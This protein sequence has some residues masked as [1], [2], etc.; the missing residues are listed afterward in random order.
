MR[1][2]AQRIVRSTRPLWWAYRTT[3]RLRWRT[4]ARLV[5]EAGASIHRH[6]GYVLWDPEVESHSFTLANR[7]ELAVFASQLLGVPVGRVGVVLAELD[8]DPELTTRLTTRL[9]WRCWFK[10]RM[11]FG[12]RELWYV[13]ARLLRPSLIVETGIYDGLG[14]L[15]LLRAL[16]ANA[17]EGAPGE[18]I[19]V[20]DVAV[21]GELVARRLRGRWTKLTGLSSEVVEPAIAGRFVGLL[22]HDTPHTEQNQRAEFA[23]GLRHAADPLVI[24]EGSGGHC[25]TLDQLAAVL[26]LQRHH[27][28]DRAQGFGWSGGHGVLLV[29][30]DAHNGTTPVWPPL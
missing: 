28:A 15:V 5:K 23:L 7:D 24:V 2:R 16:E 3:G 12:N 27:F 14:S 25:P 29:P 6:L 10:N 8:D 21:S 26:G 20:D 11:S 19:S 9:R 22:L 1:S 17:Q 4:K 30:R 13:L 18:L